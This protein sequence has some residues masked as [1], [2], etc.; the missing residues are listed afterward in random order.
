MATHRPANNHILTQ[1]EKSSI[2]VE[3]QTEGEELS[4]RAGGL[5]CQSQNYSLDS[6]VMEVMLAPEP[7][8]RATHAPSLHAAIVSSQLQKHTVICSPV[9]G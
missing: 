7:Q 2:F 4:S 3:D 6:K 1:T 5:S 8:Q 9:T